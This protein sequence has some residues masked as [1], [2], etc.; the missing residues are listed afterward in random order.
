MIRL[1]VYLF[2][3][4]LCTSPIWV[5]FVLFMWW[6]SSFDSCPVTVSCH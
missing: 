6:M 1:F 4:L 5:P 3:I 2:Y